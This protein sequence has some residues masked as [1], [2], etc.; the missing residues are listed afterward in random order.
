MYL[1]KLEQFHKYKEM[2]EGVLG[3]FETPEAI[4]H[5]AEKAK[6]K[7]YKGF[8][9]ILPYPVHGIDEAMGTPRS[10]LPW[11][12]F[13]AGIFGCTI[14][15]LFQYLT[16]AYDWPLNI[17]GKSLNAW[18]A[19]VPIIFELTVFSA[20]IYTVAALCFLSG[21]PKATRRIL[22]PDL[23]SHRF[24]LWIPKSAKGYNESEVVSFVK[25]LGGSEVT[26]VKPENQK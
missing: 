1:P 13:F 3:I 24:G 18:F 4:M 22:H 19:Y 8:D 16:H 6:E 14:G 2:D 10:G 11:I 23:T 26:V 20:G 17:S 15:I 9:C 7:D 12:T 21:I 5:A 25:G